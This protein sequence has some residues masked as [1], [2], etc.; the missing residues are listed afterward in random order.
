MRK[1][2]VS[3]R[4]ARHESSAFWRENKSVGVLNK[5]DVESDKKHDA[6]SV[7]IVPEHMDESVPVLAIAQARRKALYG[8]TSSEDE[9]DD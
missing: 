4:S 3:R 2:L 5:S 6:P 8:S 7:V 9:G 1:A